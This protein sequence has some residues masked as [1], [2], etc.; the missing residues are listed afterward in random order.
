MGARARAD[1]G[2]GRLQILTDPD[3]P[4]PVLDVVDAALAAGAPTI[5]VRAKAGTDRSRFEQVAAV[6][7][8]CRGRGADCIVNDRV[9]LA[10][11][12]GA[13][14]VHLGDDDLPVPDAR[15]L[16]GSTAVI[17]AT[18]RSADGARR[19]EADGASYIGIGPTFATATKQVAVP[20]LAVEG[21][22][23]IAAA[24][25]LP[26]VAIAGITADLAPSVLAAGVTGLAV[27]G[28]VSRAPDPGAAT[29][30]LLDIIETAQ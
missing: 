22:A 4:H 7:E 24:T 20:V 30:F 1:N 2:F 9:D 3:G 27:V 6:L 21:V 10:L 8:R 25:T 5:Q 29:A 13:D 16:M 12:A 19:A 11:A 28:A 17:G 18:V 14:G 23:A 26:S 15:H